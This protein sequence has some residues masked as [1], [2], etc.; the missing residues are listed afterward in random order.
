VSGG[1][2]DMYI[3]LTSLLLIQDAVSYHIILES[4]RSVDPQ[5]HLSPYRVLPLIFPFK[6]RMQVFGMHYRGIVDTRDA[7]WYDTVLKECLSLDVNDFLHDVS[8]YVTNRPLPP[9]YA[10]ATTGG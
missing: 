8:S 1:Y 5:H 6:L 10:A 7:D 2:V 9:Y 3:S 4:R